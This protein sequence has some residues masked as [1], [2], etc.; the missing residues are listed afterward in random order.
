MRERTPDGTQAPARNSVSRYPFAERAAGTGDATGVCRT[1][2]R[3]GQETSMLL[4]VGP[5]AAGKDTVAEELERRGF[6]SVI[7]HTTRPSRGEGDRHVFVTKDEADEMWDDA[8][9]KTIFDGHRYFATQ[10]DIRKAD[11]YI[12]D[13]SGAYEI[14]G[15]MPGTDFVICYIDADD[16]MR[17]KMA[18]AREEDGQRAERIFDERE[19]DERLSFVRFERELALRLAN[20]PSSLPKNVR[21][22]VFLENDYRPESIPQMADQ[23]EHS[24]RTLG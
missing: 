3:R 5:S 15:K 12:V 4:I 11:L 13:P 22:I 8:V 24:M 19:R 20:G 6:S 17:R 14:T 7:S 16:E 23:L 21:E 1:A 18:I 10:D 2:R 9:A